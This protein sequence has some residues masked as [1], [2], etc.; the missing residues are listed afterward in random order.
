MTLLTP[1]F[2]TS[3]QGKEVYERNYQSVSQSVA[4]SPNLAIAFSVQEIPVLASGRD[5]LSNFRKF[6]QFGISFFI[7]D[8][9]F[10]FSKTKC[11]DEQQLF[12][13]IFYVAWTA[14]VHL[15]RTPTSSQM[16][17]SFSQ[18]SCSSRFFT[19]GEQE[20]LY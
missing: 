13:Q 12:I 4:L 8:L 2:F 14:V 1:Q 7:V 16:N 11:L 5:I 10:P 20:L 15:D 6:D 19:L 17:R 3:C 18:S 9:S